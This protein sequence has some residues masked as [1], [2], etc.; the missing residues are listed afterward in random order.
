MSIQEEAV[1]SEGEEKVL[2]EIREITQDVRDEVETPGGV[3]HMGDFR[4]LIMRW[5]ELL[6]TKP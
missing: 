6:E 4:R 3:E 1:M 5:G 2:A